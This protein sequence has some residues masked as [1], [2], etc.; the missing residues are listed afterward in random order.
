MHEQSHHVELVKFHDEKNIPIAI[1]EQ[2]KIY[3]T[4][5]I[6][7]PENLFSDKRHEKSL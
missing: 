5:A 1:K 2:V 6:L 3:L 4:A 7:S